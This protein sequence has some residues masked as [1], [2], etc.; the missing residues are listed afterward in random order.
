MTNQVWRILFLESDK[1]NSDQPQETKRLSKV[2]ISGHSEL[3]E[4]SV[5]LFCDDQK[6]TLLV[7]Y[8]F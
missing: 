3:V 4:E 6:D 1:A 7:F 5:R 2:K 8:P